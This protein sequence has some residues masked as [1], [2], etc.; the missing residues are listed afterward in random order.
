MLVLVK[1]RLDQTLLM[2]R[3]RKGILLPQFHKM[4]E[5]EGQNLD[6]GQRAGTKERK[7][8]RMK[9]TRKIRK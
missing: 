9:V 6:A 2:M 7:V 3:T 5:R 1:P 4:K 8:E